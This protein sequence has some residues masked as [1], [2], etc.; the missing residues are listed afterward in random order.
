[1]LSFPFKLMGTEWEEQG[2]WSHLALDL[3]CLHHSLVW[4]LGNLMILGL[5]ALIHKMG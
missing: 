2:L 1:M 4:P 3:I 5:S